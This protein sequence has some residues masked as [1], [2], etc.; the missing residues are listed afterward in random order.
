MILTKYEQKSN[1]LEIYRNIISNDNTISLIEAST[2]A[3]YASLAIPSL[4]D[5]PNTKEKNSYN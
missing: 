2:Q 4:L 1:K 5:F 3:R